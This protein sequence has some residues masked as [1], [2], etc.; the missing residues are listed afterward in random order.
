MHCCGKQGVFWYRWLLFPQEQYPQ[1]AAAAVTD[2]INQQ[3]CLQQSSVAVEDNKYEIACKPC[4]FEESQIN[5][6][7]TDCVASS[8]C[9]CQDYPVVGFSSSS[10]VAPLQ[11]HCDAKLG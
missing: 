7:K 10:A 2:S 5:L 1:P 3:T 9:T 8:R 4:H 11:L 6:G